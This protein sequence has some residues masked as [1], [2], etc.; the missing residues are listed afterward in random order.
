[1][2]ALTHDDKEDVVAKPKG[3]HYQD[4]WI[5]IAKILN[6]SIKQTKRTLDTGFTVLGQQFVNAMV[7]WLLN[8]ELHCSWGGVYFRDEL[9]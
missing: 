4:L 2:Y 8:K 1:M 9:F 5:N 7:A 3:S 6:V